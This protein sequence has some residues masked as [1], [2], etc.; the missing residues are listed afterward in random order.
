MRRIR[1]SK[2]MVTIRI[3]YEGTKVCVKCRENEVTTF[4][5]QT[6]GGR[7]GCSLRPHLFY[8]FTNDMME[9]IN[10]DNSHAPS[11]GR[12][13]I[14]RLL[15]TDDLAVYSFTSNGLEKEIDQIVRYCKE[16]TLKCNLSKSKIVVFKKGGKLKNT[17]RWNMGGQNI[18]TK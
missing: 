4:T 12:T 11:I 16:W 5:S 18:D 1:I 17:E 10:V 14:P 15:F 9:Y 3:M 8:I 6:R 2:N 13:T 7:Q